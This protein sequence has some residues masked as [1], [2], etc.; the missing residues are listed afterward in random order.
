MHSFCILEK[1]QVIKMMLKYELKKIFSKRINQVLLAAVLVV[2]VIY[3]GMAIGSMRYTDE[4]GQDHTGIE[5]GRLLAEDKNHW[6]GDLTAETISQ[7]IKDYKELSAKYPD[8]IPD[9]EYGKTIQSY[10]DIKDF[11]IGI[12]T[13]NSE[14][15]ESVLNQLSDEQL[16]D[17][18][19]IYQ[20]NMKKMA[21]EYGTTPEKRSYL[22]SI[23]E[24]IEIPLT[25]EAKDS[26][27][28]MTMYAQTYV[29]LMAVV[30]GF[31]AASIFSEEFQPGT[32]DV[33][34][35][36]RYG[37]SKTIKIKI[38]AGI[39]MATVVYW[40]GVGIL[41]L[42]SFAVMGTS[43]FSTL[44]QIDN[45]YS[46]YVMTY[47]EYYLLILMGGYIAT[48]FCAALTMSVTVKMHTPNLAVCIPFFLLCMMQFI[49]STLTSFDRFFNL[50]PTV[51]TNIYN[52]VRKPIIFQI[53]PLVFRQI[54]FLMFLYSL[55]FLILLLFIYRSYSRYG[56]KRK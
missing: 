43:G 52:A 46:I 54:P 56:L 18:Y 24:K 33:F 35:A 11:V 21:E 41:S 13:P 49:E 42:I 38:I 25:F 55:L 50:M 15:D 48:L 32:E 30:I 27:D 3:S 28:T 6:K 17:I 9:T 36:S 40:I 22:E 20:G 51:L 47:G 1:R 4:E 10:Y 14:W 31:L 44:Y 16:E 34:L 37:R 19:T 7:V 8:G 2:T 26:W 5:A 39:L 53:G 12:M 23:Y 29:M 45:P